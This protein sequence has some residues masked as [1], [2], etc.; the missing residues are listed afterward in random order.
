MM[1]F[2][3]ILQLIISLLPA[4][5]EAVDKVEKVLPASDQGT[6]KL[7][8]VRGM[9]ESTYKA[10]GDASIAFDLVWPAIKGT[11]EA[12]VLA[13]NKTGIFEQSKPSGSE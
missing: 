9:I 11:V 3:K 2:L 8:I 7:A 6:Q 1:Q 13:F 4:L 10:A 5:A 12:L